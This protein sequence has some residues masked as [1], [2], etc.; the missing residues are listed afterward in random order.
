MAVPRCPSLCCNCTEG[1]ELQLRRNT[2]KEGFVY[3]CCLE[4]LANRIDTGL[5]LSETSMESWCLSSYSHGPPESR[6]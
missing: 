5:A 3:L 6:D 1:T 2:A 4:Y